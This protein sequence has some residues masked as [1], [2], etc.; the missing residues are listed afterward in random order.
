[1]KIR[2]SLLTLMA[3]IISVNSNAQVL[4]RMQQKYPNAD[5]VH[6]QYS[7]D[8]RFYMQDGLPMAEALVQQDLMLLNERTASFFTR[9][10]VYHSGYNELQWMEAHTVL[11]DSKK[12]LPVAEKKTSS[13]TSNAIFYD[14]LKETSFDYPSL[15]AGAITQLRYSI[16][17]NEIRL[18]NP[19]IYAN[20]VPVERLS[21]SVS[22]PDDI[23]IGY[24]VRNDEAGRFAM[25]TERKK[26]ITTYR[27]EIKEAEFEDRYVD[28]PDEY[29]YLPHIIIYGHL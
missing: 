13:A 10:R 21:F 19:F 1:M 24:I 8:I 6:L 16:R 3:G 14:D 22:V 25:T 26:Q 28:A 9:S 20:G 2:N 29:Y 27:W 7:R 4:A 11:P 18:I 15:Q 23:E 5:A 17:H 12:K